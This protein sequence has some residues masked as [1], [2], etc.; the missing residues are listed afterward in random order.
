MSA[1]INET[2]TLN[3]AG[4]L[5]RLVIGVMLALAVTAGLFWTM[6]YLIVSADKGLNENTA[7]NI[8]DFVRLKRN[9]E[10]KL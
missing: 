10:I 3:R 7:G 9:E 5:V 8:V 2:L 4:D 6:Q 1:T